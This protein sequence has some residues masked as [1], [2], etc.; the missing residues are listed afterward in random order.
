MPKIHTFKYRIGSKYENEF[1]RILRR[2][3]VDP[4]SVMCRKGSIFHTP[5]NE[6]ILSDGLYRLIQ[7]DMN[8]LSAQNT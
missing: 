6:Y 5:Y 3:D 8:E 1:F 7:D 2:Y 4:K